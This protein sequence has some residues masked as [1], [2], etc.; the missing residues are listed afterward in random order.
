MI[1]NPSFAEL[2]K[3][4]FNRYQLTIV[5]A[6]MARIVNEEYI[7]LRE[8]IEQRKQLAI[9]RGGDKNA[10][11]S[12]M[13]PRYRDERAVRVAVDKISNNECKIEILDPSDTAAQDSDEN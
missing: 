4:R 7:S 9:Q 3:G 6:K 13:N 1:T 8:A 5:A 2:S 11:D 10:F 12:Y